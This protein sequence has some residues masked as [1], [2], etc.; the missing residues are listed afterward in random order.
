MATSIHALN[1]LGQSIWYDNIRRGLLDSGELARLIEAGVSGVTSN[2][3]IFEKAI[4]GSNDYDAAITELVRRGLDAQAIYDQLTLEDIGRGADLLRPVYDRTN[5][6]DGYISIEVPPT[7]AADTPATVAEARRIFG[8]LNR[9]NVMIKVP[10]TPEGIPAIRTL[11]ADGVN[12]NVT[13]IFSLKTYDDVITAYWEGLED[14]L[15]R[16][17]PVDRVASV[18]S[19]FVSRVDTLVDKL[20]DER[21]L[22][23]ALR[24]KAAV[25]NAKLAYELF[26]RRSAEPRWAALAAKGARVQRPLWASTSTKNP[27]YPPLLYVD[28]LIGPH[29]VNTL[30]PQTVEAV[31]QSVKV[32]R[33]V[34]ADL[35]RA[36]AD[37]EALEAAGISMD[38][39]TDQLMQQ[40]VK[41]FEDS[42][43]SLMAGLEKKVAA[44]A[45]G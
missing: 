35:D 25:A 8:T 39:V 22:D 1:E 17:L 29:T 45:A 2:P 12:V 37:L 43:A 19:F 16:G 41:A 6:E 30:P 10:A 3:T 28:T 33:T 36:H 38:W 9:P 5:G 42:F 13:L 23:P 32:A 18:A 11:I 31:L 15:Q 40:G 27:A 26:Q 44:V 20:I 4:G 21:G 24:G 14:R 34:D 7:L